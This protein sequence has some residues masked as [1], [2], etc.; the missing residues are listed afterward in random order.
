MQSL[1]VG[2]SRDFNAAAAMPMRA[3]LA[4]GDVVLHHLR[5]PAE[6]AD[7]VFLRDEID[8]SV[9]AAAGR[10]TFEGLEKKETTAVSCSVS[11]SAAN[12]SARSASFRWGMN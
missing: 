2:G 3:P 9:H 10:A 12:G 5:T 6:I 8:L 7:I 11:S 1:Q 4:L